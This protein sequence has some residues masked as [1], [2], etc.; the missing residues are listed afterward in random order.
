MILLYALGVA[1]AGSMSQT[2]APLLEADGEVVEV[3]S[4]PL[5]R[6]SG[7]R[8]RIDT[9]IGVPYPAVLYAE[10]NRELQVV[11]LD[12]RLVVACEL[13]GEVER[14][15]GEARCR[16][17]DAAV[18][19][20]PWLRD[21]PDAELVLA[22]TDRRL[23]GLEMVLQVDDAGRVIDVGLIGEPQTNSRVN[24][25][26]ENLRQMLCRAMFG[27]HVQSPDELQVGVEFIERN[28]RLLTIPSFRYSVPSMA[29]ASA[30]DVARVDGR[31]RGDL[32]GQRGVSADG[33]G[34]LT[35]NTE[36][37]DDVGL[38]SATVAQL[39]RHPM[40]V[41]QAPASYGRSTI[42][43]R[44]DRWRGAFVMQSTGEGTA[45]IGADVPMVFQGDLSAVAVFDPRLGFMTER[46][47]V[48]QMAPTASSVLS[49]GVK[50][51]SFWQ[52]GSL[53]MLGRD[54]ASP[55]G[56]SMLVAPPQ[57]PAGNLPPWPAL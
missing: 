22:E 10:F 42:A 3:V 34:S 36:F 43:H 20:G 25:I 28:S 48:V 45:D 29:A 54:E 19:A 38:R 15:R 49:D 32:L 35:P 26:Y 47:W 39:A 1:V 5:A 57:R 8:W 46:R 4:N 14:G 44:L 18:S 50:G 56:P 9:Q 37:D 33:A 16:V 21:P 23:T 27:F 12:L 6:W 52:L 55:V 17:E 41:L 2:E 13:D 30:G 24:V 53:T 7:T 40:E 51:W 11:S 31:G